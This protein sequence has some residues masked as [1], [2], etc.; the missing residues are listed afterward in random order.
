VLQKPWTP[1]AL[2]AAL[3]QAHPRKR[4]EGAAPV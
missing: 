4:A 1:P 2:A 3:E